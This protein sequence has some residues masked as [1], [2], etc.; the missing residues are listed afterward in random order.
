MCF[1]FHR[2]RPRPFFR[3]F[4]TAFRFGHIV[5]SIRL[6]ALS[7]SVESPDWLTGDGPKVNSAA[8][9][10]SARTHPVGSEGKNQRVQEGQLTRYTPAG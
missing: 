5:L 2:L 6:L 1:H 9:D 7:H 8:W 4:G 3:P 10:A